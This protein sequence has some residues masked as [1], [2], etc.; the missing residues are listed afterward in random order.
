MNVPTKLDFSQEVRAERLSLLWKVTIVGSLFLVWGTLI[1][2]SVSAVSPINF[3]VPVV[4]IIAGCLACRWL[5]GSGRY[6]K[7]VWAYVVGLMLGLGWMLHI[8]G[9]EGGDSLRVLGTFG[10]PLLIM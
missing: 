5:L 2:T 6:T 9:S 8:P 7:A 4:V 10:Y 3:F 1:L